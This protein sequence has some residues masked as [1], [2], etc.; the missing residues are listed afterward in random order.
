MFFLTHSYFPFFWHFTPFVAL[1][2]IVVEVAIGSPDRRL[3][4]WLARAVACCVLVALV[5]PTLWTAAHLRRTNLD[6]ISLFLA[7]R[8][9]SKDL[10]LVNPVWLASGFNYHYHGN[11]EWNTMPLVSCKAEASLDPDLAVKQLVA[12]PNAIDSALTKDRE[13]AGGRPSPLDHR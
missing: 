5:V 4:I 1:A 7:E 9:G 13:H 11:T 3:W 10:I 8:A 12:T 6:R 2:G